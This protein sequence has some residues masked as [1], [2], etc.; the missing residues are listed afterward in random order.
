MSRKAD[1][2][3]STHQPLPTNLIS[4]QALELTLVLLR[5]T[6]PSLATA[7]KQTLIELNTVS[8][9]NTHPSLNDDMHLYAELLSR[10]DVQTISSIMAELN[11]VAQKALTNEALYP[12]ARTIMSQLLQEWADLVEWVLLNSTIDRRQYH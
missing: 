4:H 1:F 2:S 7:V 8:E 9:Q 12:E 5:S 3:P 10:L 11:A 6:K